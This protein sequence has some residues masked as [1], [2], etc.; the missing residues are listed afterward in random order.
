MRAC[1][2]NLWRHSSSTVRQELKCAQSDQTPQAV[3]DWLVL[4]ISNGDAAEV[5]SVLDVALER[6][7]AEAM[8]MIQGST[9]R[10]VEETVFVGNA[11]V[12][13][14]FSNQHEKLRKLSQMTQK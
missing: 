6:G 8:E 5:D 13:S 1:V 10:L 14:D 4:A 7:G 12:R 3:T 9:Q 11:Q 2:Q